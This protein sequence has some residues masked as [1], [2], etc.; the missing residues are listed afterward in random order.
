MADEME[1]EKEL[2][3]ILKLAKCLKHI[4]NE[5]EDKAEAEIQERVEQI[6]IIKC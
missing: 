5:M 6:I 2:T 1:D 3:K 4:N